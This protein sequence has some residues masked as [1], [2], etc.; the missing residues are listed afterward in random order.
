MPESAY[1]TRTEAMLAAVLQ[2]IETAT[3]NLVAEREHPTL[4][5]DV[6]FSAFHKGMIAG[7]EETLAA[8]ARAIEGALS[9][10]PDN[11]PYREDDDRG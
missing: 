5:P 9:E 1:G 8:L 6:T 10:H 7:V 2:V 3:N 4:E 11:G